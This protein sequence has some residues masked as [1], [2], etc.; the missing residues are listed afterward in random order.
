MGKRQFGLIVATVAGA[1]LIFAGLVLR[2]VVLERV[3]SR[4]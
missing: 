3:W 1:A 2:Y 4:R